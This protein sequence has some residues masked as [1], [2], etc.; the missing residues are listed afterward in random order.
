MVHFMDQGEEDVTHTPYRATELQGHLEIPAA[1]SP[2]QASVRYDRPGYHLVFSPRTRQTSSDYY[3]S[4]S[5]LEKST[6]LSL[7]AE[8]LFLQ[9]QVEAALREGRTMH[10]DV[11]ARERAW[12]TTIWTGTG[13]RVPRGHSP[14]AYEVDGKGTH[15]Y[16]RIVLHG[17]EEVGE[18]SVPESHGYPVAAWDDVFGIPT[19]VIPVSWEQAL[20]PLGRTTILYF[21]PRDEKDG[22]SGQLD[23]ALVRWGQSHLFG[24]N[25]DTVLIG[26]DARHPRSYANHDFSIRPVAG[27][28]PPIL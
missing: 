19:D 7:A 2:A 18:V 13:L 4:L 21:T 24:Q 16:R 1:S 3:S 12:R 9:R 15:R 5:D 14:I 25:E 6:R 10:D 23:V 20:S 28:L 8:E 22:V 27:P 11:Y 17:D 26:V